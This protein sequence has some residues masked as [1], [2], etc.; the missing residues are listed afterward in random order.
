MN[1]NFSEFTP[2]NSTGRKTHFWFRIYCIVMTLV[3]LVLAGVGVY[4]FIVQPRMQDL[5]KNQVAI[6]G[7]AYMIVGGLLLI[8]FA[9][10]PFLPRRRWVWVFGLVLICLGLTS[11]CFLP[12]A[13]PLL[14]FWIKPQTKA[15]FGR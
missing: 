2:D 13:I 8:P 5:S 4:L 6:M 1:Q 11:P 9:I 15:L 10:A 12:F 14:I 3:Y 7:V